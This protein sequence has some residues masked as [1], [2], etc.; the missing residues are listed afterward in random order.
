M[1]GLALLTICFL[2]LCILFLNVNS[3]GIAFVK[4]LLAFTLFQLI[5]TETLSFFNKIDFFSF[6]FTYLSF[7]AILIL[8]IYLRRDKKVI[9][10]YP[11]LKAAR[12]LP[13]IYVIIFGLFFFNLAIIIFVSFFYPPNNWDANTCWLAR[14]EHWISNKSLAFYPTHINLQNVHQPLSSIIF[15]NVRLLT[16]TDLFINLTQ[17]I[18]VIGSACILLEIVKKHFRRLRYQIVNLVIVLT[19]PLLVLQM[20]S[21]KNDLIVSFFFISSL[22][23]LLERIELGRFSDILWFSVSIALAVLT[24]FSI[25]PFLVVF[26]IYYFLKLIIHNHRNAIT[27]FIISL[28]VVLLLVSPYLVRNYKSCGNIIGNLQVNDLRD[29][30][31]E[32]RGTSKSNYFSRSLSVMIKYTGYALSNPVPLIN[33]NIEKGVIKADAILNLKEQDVLHSKY[34]L[35]NAAK[36]N[37]DCKNNLI[38]FFFLILSIPFILKQNNL[39]LKEIILLSFVSFLLFCLIFPV[40]DIYRGRYM[41]PLLI[42][43][44]IPVTYFI[45]SKFNRFLLLSFIIVML[46]NGV[47]V[48]YKNLLRPFPPIKELTRLYASYIK[49]IPGHFSNKDDFYDFYKNANN[50]EKKVIDRI[51]DSDGTLL[52]QKITSEDNLSC[53]NYLVKYKVIY[54]DYKTS[55]ISHLSFNIGD[56]QFIKMVDYIKRNRFTEIGLYVSK[57]FQEY[58]LWCVLDANEKGIK[59][60]AVKAENFYNKLKPFSFSPAYILVFDRPDF[61][62]CFNE[63]IELKKFGSIILLKRKPIG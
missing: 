20:T 59:I 12:R 44:S 26:L 23:F 61:N 28:M 15:L 32:M 21:A 46:M 52:N 11:F 4:S 63:Y 38:F 29:F 31:E 24:K 16:K 45:V 56:N 33:E 22:Y 41:L 19:I 7:L 27:V 58:S 50:E 17:F 49:H 2:S 30:Q 8:G 51:Y 43:L 36:Y 60:E 39:L 34:D 18:F 53:Y 9:K 62:T 40:Y 14:V 35:S 42:L 37:E 55:R 1:L 48:S 47:F 13:K 5:L 10:I 25:I 6:I 54:S 3:L 57:D